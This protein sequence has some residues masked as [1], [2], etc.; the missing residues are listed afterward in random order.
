MSELRRVET[1][2]DL[3]DEVCESIAARQVN[4]FQELWAT[5]ATF[6]ADHHNHPLKA[7]ACGTAFCRAGWMC[8]ILDT[9]RGIKRDTG[10]W[11]G[12][13]IQERARCLLAG[14]G[15]YTDAINNLFSGSA[16]GTLNFGEPG[17]VE[18]GIA[19]M[20]RFMAKHEAKLKA[21]RIPEG[22]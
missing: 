16:L 10:E 22:A 14:A 6:Q 18:E 3:C 20:R 5:D 12:A 15:I 21:A 4:Y 17:Y 11:Q 8:A 2:W 7:E 9:Q 13:N 1:L 19:G